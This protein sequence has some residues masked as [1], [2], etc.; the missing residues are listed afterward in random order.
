MCTRTPKTPSYK[1]RR[2]LGVS[3]DSNQSTK[4]TEQRSCFTVLSSKDQRST[5]TKHHTC[6]KQEEATTEQNISWI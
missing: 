3:L 6:T 5:E 1:R 4:T 2:V